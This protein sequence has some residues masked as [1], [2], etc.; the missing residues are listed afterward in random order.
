M[1]AIYRHIEKH[2]EES[3]ADLARLCELPSI[4]ARS[5]H[6]RDGG[7]RPGCWRRGLRTRI[8]P[9]RRQ[10]PVVYGELRRLAEDAGLQPLRRPAAGAAG[11]VE[12]AALPAH[13]PG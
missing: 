13:A 8:L 2:L 9:S 3:L 1:D 5:G 6:W 10:H 4:S 11:A 7:V 12:L